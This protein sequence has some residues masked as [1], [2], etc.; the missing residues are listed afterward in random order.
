MGLMEGEYIPIYKKR[1]PQKYL[2]DPF[3]FVFLCDQRAKR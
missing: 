3:V 2:R 1:I